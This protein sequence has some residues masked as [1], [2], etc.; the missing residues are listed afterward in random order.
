MDD[1]SRS[2]VRGFRNS[3]PR[4]STFSLWPEQENGAFKFSVVAGR[5]AGAQ[6]TGGA[7][8]NRDYAMPRI[9]KEPDGAMMRNLAGRVA[10]EL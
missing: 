4:P 7:K 5:L 2:E 8:T 9:E 1:G 6:G 3:E 10:P